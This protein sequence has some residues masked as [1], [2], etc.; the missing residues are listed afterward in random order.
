MSELKQGV[1]TQVVGEGHSPGPL[2]PQEKKLLVEK[3]TVW[4]FDV[5]WL[6]LSEYLSY[7]EQKGTSQN[8]ASFVGEATLRMHGPGHDNRPATH[9]E[10]DRMCAVFEEEML[11]GALGLGTSLIYPPA[12]FFSTEELISLASVAA[13]HRGKYISHMRSEGARL[14]EAIDELVRISREAGLPAEIWHLKAAG[15]DHW[16][17][18][19]QA[20]DRIE[21]ARA[22]G[23]AIRAN[24]YTYTAGATGLA[25]SIPPW[26]HEGGPP[27]LYD[28]LA[29]AAER[30]KM[31]AA[32]LDGSDHDWENLSQRVGGP[33]G[34]LILGVRT[35]RNR[36]YQGKNLAQVAEMMGVDPIDAMFDLIKSDR[37]RVET[38]YFMISE[39]NVRL[40]L[41]QPWVSIGSD[42]A[43]SAPEGVFLKMSTHPRAYG[44]FA[45]FLGKYVREEGLLPLPEAIRRITSL[46]AE[47]LDLDR[48]GRLAEGYFADLVV[49]DPQ[50]VADRATYEDP[51][52][53]AVGV[54]DVV[55]NGKVTLRDGEFSGALAGRALYGPGRRAR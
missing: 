21:E 34:I 36:K 43:S 18:M 1:T 11:D 38:A 25:N 15:Q 31:R 14:L 20:I 29:D 26:F 7:V 24:M 19:H 16:H 49:F 12:F 47:N 50:T 10:M 27:K 41:S 35:D 2:T 13:R 32:I 33:E 17:K 4:K 46:P 55:V 22:D 8:F 23:L 52:K 48:R 42:A 3:Q 45:R 54:R 5:P 44:C 28:R 9:E 39:E 6:R 40:G 53:Y 37:S 30:A 51:Q